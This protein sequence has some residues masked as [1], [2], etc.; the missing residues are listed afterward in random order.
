MIERAHNTDS[1]YKAAYSPHCCVISV[2]NKYQSSSKT[3]VFRLPLRTGNGMLCCKERHTL[4]VEC[5]VTFLGYMWRLRGATDIIYKPLYGPHGVISAQ[6]NSHISLNMFDLGH[7][8]LYM[9]N[10]MIFSKER[11]T[12]LLKCSITFL[13]CIELIGRASNSVY[14]HLVVHTESFL[15]KI[16][17]KFHA[18]YHISGTL[19]T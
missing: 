1:I 6:N 11:N 7:S 12:L 10:G 2:K 8:P 14:K 5:F 4:L 3:S 18:K 16:T 19:S 13:R 17:H 9:R 15:P